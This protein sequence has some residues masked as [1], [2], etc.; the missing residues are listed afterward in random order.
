MRDAAGETA[1]RFELLR[2]PELLFE[3]P[4]L[5]DVLH[6]ADHAPRDA[7]GAA[8]DVPFLVHPAHLAV[9]ADDAV[10]DVVGEIAFLRR[11]TRPRNEVAIVGVHERVER[12]RR[13]VESIARDAENPVRFVRPRQAI[14][15]VEVGDPA[16]D[17]RHFLRLF[18]KRAMLLE[19][20]L[21]ADGLGDVAV[22]RDASDD[23]PVDAMRRHEALVDAPVFESE[24][25]EDLDRRIGPRIHR[26][27]DQLCGVFDFAGKPLGN[28]LDVAMFDLVGRQVKHAQEL[29]VVADDTALEVEHEQAVVRGL[30]RLFEEGDLLL[31][32]DA[33]L[34]V[35]HGRP[36]G[37]PS[38]AGSNW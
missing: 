7:I 31:R 8:H 16:S 27:D 5:G 11:R 30:Q 24:R 38:G 17:V 19:Q 34:A 22:A 6:R 4:S 15:A 20:R 12:G 10:I 2:L 1:D 13:A 21:R 37:A 29:A 3:H 32:A 25:V 28:D 35:R 33:C 14:G 9:R 18:E 23:V 36:A 26:V